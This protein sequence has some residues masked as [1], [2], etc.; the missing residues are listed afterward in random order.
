[1]SLVFKFPF[2]CIIGRMDYRLITTLNE[3]GNLADAWNALLDQSANHVPF[4]RYEYLSTW[5]ETL[6]GGEWQ[7]ATLAVVV[8]FDGDRLV[9]GAP[10]F[11]CKNR[12]GEPALL[13]IGS[14]EVSD[15]LD[16]V[17]RPADLPA[18]LDGLLDFLDTPASPDWKVLDWYNILHQSPT[19]PALAEAAK[20][21]GWDYR[22][23][24]LQHSPY[25]PLPGDWETYLARIDKKQRHEI[26]RKMR[27]LEESGVPW[28]WYAAQDPATLDAEVDAFMVMM[29]QDPDKA[30][31]LTEPMRL[32]FRKVAR[33]AFEAD[34]LQMAFLEINGQKAAGYFSFNYLDRIWVYNSAINQSLIE[35]SPGWVLLGNLLKWANQNGITEFDFMRG[36]EEYKYRFGGVDRYVKRAIVKR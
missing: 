6:G 27:R 34:C 15:F 25:I 35:Y 12:D 14:I 16:M 8:A 9:G 26:R 17:A 21:H 7:E 20:A 1:M 3:W 28:R 22:E 23:E 31:F 18:F 24:I 29:V 2:A 5:W 30:R 4:L 10:L 13:L 11:F 32:H 36:N 33:C 19:L